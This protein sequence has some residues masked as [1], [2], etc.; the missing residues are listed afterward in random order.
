MMTRLNPALVYLLVRGLWSLFEGTFL[1]LL[2]V[3]YIQNAGMNP[4]Q[5]VL[6]DTVMQV[7]ILVFEVPTGVVADTY[8]R[9]LSV[10]IGM[11]MG[12]LCFVVEGVFPVFILIVL[13]EFLRAIG[14][15]FISGAFSAWITDEIGVEKVGRVLMRANQASLITG[16]VST[17]IGIWLSTFLPLG[18]MISGGGVGL[19]LVAV[20]MIFVM[21]EENFKPA[22]ESRSGSL[23]QSLKTGWQVVRGRPLALTIVALGLVFG[24]SDAGFDRLWEAHFIKDFTIPLFSPAAW[25]GFLWIGAQPANL[26]L[27]EILIRRIKLGNSR[28]ILV[29]SM[30]TNGSLMVSV[31]I[32]A[33]APNFYVALVACL[34]GRTFRTTGL[35]PVWV[36]RNLDARVR[37]T[38][39]SFDSQVEAV[40]HL[41]GG[42]LTGFI[43]TA[44]SVPAALLT[45]ALLLSPCWLLFGYALRLTREE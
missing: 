11:L 44:V 8:S 38:V 25:F 18:L 5:L 41:L 43:G 27:L 21:S 32:F 16:M 39:I 26:L 14:V 19:A 42:P 40:G 2:P 28:S 37:A 35:F 45:S 13:A 24:S 1:F 33:L 3:Y 6:V 23:S 31:V 30:V 20:F 10:I 17:G 7:T 29:A 36:N 12:G 22:K 34:A 9:K 4:L 15:T